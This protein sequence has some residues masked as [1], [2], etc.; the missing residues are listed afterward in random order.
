M[1]VMQTATLLLIALKYITDKY[2]E[3]TKYSGIK[4]EV[5][6]MF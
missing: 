6:E 1:A 5:S 2:I 3:L 4:Y